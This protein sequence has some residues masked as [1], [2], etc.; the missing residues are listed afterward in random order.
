MATVWEHAARGRFPRRR[1][2]DARIVSHM[3][4]AKHIAEYIAV[5]L[6]SAS[7]NILPLPLALGLGW[8]LAILAFHVLHYRRRETQRRI[9]LVLGPSRS[10]ADV[11]RIAWISLRNLCFNVV[12]MMRAARLDAAWMR[13][14]IDNYEPAIARLRDLLAAHG[15]TVLAL[16]HCGNWDLAGIAVHRAG[17]PIFTVAGV[18]KNPLLNAWMNRQRG[19]GIHVLPRGS[20]TLRQVVQRLRQGQAF[21]ILSDVR[22][23]WADLVVPFLGGQANIGRGMA[24]FA[25]SAHV[26]VLPVLVTRVG[27]RRHRSRVLDPIFPDPDADKEADLRRITERVLAGMDAAIRAEPEQWFWYNKRWVLDP[28]N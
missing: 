23:R 21:A 27:W 11:R 28:L 1:M 14:H 4:S 12:E 13:A 18:Q 26:P 16:P 8:L 2:I 17:I 6:L 5:R 3:P 22:T 10:A 9:R 25:R 7:L 15:G 24:Q 19:I 20:S